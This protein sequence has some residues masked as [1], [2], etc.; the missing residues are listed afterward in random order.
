MCTGL[1]QNKL[2]KRIE[3]LTMFLFPTFR[4][5]KKADYL[6]VTLLSLCEGLL[7][8]FGKHKVGQ[9]VHFLSILSSNLQI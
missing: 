5:R 2:A 8:L 4:E 1:E 6:F 9:F 7:Q 3:L